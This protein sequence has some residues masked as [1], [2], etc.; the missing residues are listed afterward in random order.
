MG[1]VIWPEMGRPV[2]GHSIVLGADLGWFKFQAIWGR[3]MGVSSVLG[4][5]ALSVGWGWSVGFSQGGKVVEGS[6]VGLV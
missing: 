6:P 4:T 3:G 1:W 2:L 5:V